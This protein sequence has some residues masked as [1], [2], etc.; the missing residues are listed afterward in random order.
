VKCHKNLVFF[1]SPPGLY[2][3]LRFDHEYALAYGY[4]RLALHAH[5]LTRIVV[6][7]LQSAFL[8]LSFIQ[9]YTYMHAP[10]VVTINV[11][12]ELKV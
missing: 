8:F 2:F 6:S 3:R 11:K 10:I 12:V 5:I 9:W 4:R 7:S 1:S